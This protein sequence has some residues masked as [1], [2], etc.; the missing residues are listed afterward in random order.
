[1]STTGVEG[2]T[3]PGSH[4]RTATVELRR[5]WSPE[6]K[7][8]VG[9]VGRLAP[10]KHVERLA[11]LGRRDDLQLVIVGDGVDRAK[12]QAVLPRAVFTGALYG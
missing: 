7:P 9:F 11:V 12:L 3:S 8:I 4:R 6:G 10:E 2:S 1:M 5:R